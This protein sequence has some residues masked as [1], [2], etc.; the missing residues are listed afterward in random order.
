MSK[1]VIIAISHRVKWVTDTKKDYHL[2]GF[3][4]LRR[5]NHIH[6]NNNYTSNLQRV[7]RWCVVYWAVLWQPQTPSW[8]RK[9]GNCNKTWL[10]SNKRVC[11]WESVRVP[12]FRVSVCMSICAHLSG[13][14][15]LCNSATTAAYA[16]SSMLSLT[17]PGIGKRPR[18]LQMSLCDTQQQ[19]LRFFFLN[20]NC[21]NLFVH[22][23]IWQW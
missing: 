18:M 20:L 3:G 23:C 19:H 16:Y 8:D 21:T 22:A 14:R 11:L 7:P 4:K 1:H 12:E 9:R 13:C 10:H 17:L 5:K 2:S 6:K 15:S